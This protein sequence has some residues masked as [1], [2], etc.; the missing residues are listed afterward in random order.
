M[1]RHFLKESIGSAVSRMIG[2]RG[3]DMAKSI[4]ETMPK[5]LKIL[6]FDYTIEQIPDLMEGEHRL[7]GQHDPETN[8]IKINSNLHNEQIVAETFFH[9]ILHAIWHTM[10]MEETEEEEAAVRKLSLGISTVFKD[11]PSLKEFFWKVWK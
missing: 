8:S 5:S 3:T 1:L 2:E 7:C 9:E 10:G 6:A 4:L 11:N